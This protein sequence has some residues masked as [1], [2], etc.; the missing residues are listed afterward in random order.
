MKTTQLFLMIVLTM[1]FSFGASAQT[2][3]RKSAKNIPAPITQEIK[4]SPAYAEVLFR[5]VVLEVELEDLLARYTEAFPRVKETRYELSALKQAML[6]VINVKPS[7]SGKLSLALGKMLVQQAKYIT[8]QKILEDRYNDEHPDVKS[9][10]R[11]A[12][13]FGRAINKIL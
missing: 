4:S 12:A 5:K 1:A 7:Q 6:K 11:K 10:R 9:A 8:D 2:R 13:I 3:S